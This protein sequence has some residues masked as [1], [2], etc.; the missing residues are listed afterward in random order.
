MHWACHREPR[1][2]CFLFLLQM[3]SLHLMLSHARTCKKEKWP[4]QEHLGRGM[5]G[6]GG[7]EGRG[8]RGEDL[9]NDLGQDVA[10][11]IGPVVNRETRGSSPN[12][13]LP[14]SPTSAALLRPVTDVSCR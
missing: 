12:Q 6:V 11:S 7:E 1:S 13:L 8:G 3:A 10:G 14:P 9:E 2:L 5:T 4:S